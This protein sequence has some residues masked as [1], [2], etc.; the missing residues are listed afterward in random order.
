MI[1]LNNFD[2]L[3]E[4]EQFHNT[5]SSYAN[6]LEQIRFKKESSEIKKNIILKQKIFKER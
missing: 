4:R 3:K 6:I 1:Y 2:L 5:C